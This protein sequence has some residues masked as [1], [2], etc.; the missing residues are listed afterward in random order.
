MIEWCSGLPQ[1]PVV[2]AKTQDIEKGAGIHGWHAMGRM[3]AWEAPSSLSLEMAGW[4]VVLCARFS[5]PVAMRV[6]GYTDIQQGNMYISRARGC[7]YERYDILTSTHSS[8]GTYIPKV[9][10]CDWQFG[11]GV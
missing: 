9:C 11:H 10:M 2:C 8:I 6:P 4:C 5:L 7:P 1:V 3:R